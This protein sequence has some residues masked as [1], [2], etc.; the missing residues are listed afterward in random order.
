IYMQ[1]INCYLGK[2]N[3]STLV[4]NLEKD[5]SD[6]VLL[7]EV[8]HAVLDEKIPDLCLNPKTPA[9]AVS[10]ISSCLQTLRRLGVDLDEVTAEGIFQGNLKHILN[11]FFHLSK[12]K[13]RL[14]SRQVPDGRSTPET[15]EVNVQLSANGEECTAQKV[16]GCLIGMASHVVPISWNAVGCGGRQGSPVNVVRPACSSQLPKLTKPM[17]TAFSESPHSVV[18]LK[19]SPAQH[20]SVVTPGAAGSR[21]LMS[22]V[23]RLY[24]YRD[25]SNIVAIGTLGGMVQRI[26]L[27]GNI[28]YYCIAFSSPFCKLKK[29]FSF[30]TL[31]VPN[32]HAT[33]GKHEGWDT[34][35]MPKPRQGKSRCRG[36][37][38]TTDL[39]VSKFA[40]R[41]PGFLRYRILVECL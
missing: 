22:S 28:M 9:V 26:R 4:Q 10:N 37:V 12:F 8:I 25:I 30:N 36:G 33:R 1:W 16:N 5:L 11:L 3:S 23:L 21:N 41:P 13:E 29:L 20:P 40:L 19:T 24:M 15:A 18:H 32:C 27:L 17:H 6:G 34:A 7:A 39:P 38:R 14:K 2:A 35:R 31:P